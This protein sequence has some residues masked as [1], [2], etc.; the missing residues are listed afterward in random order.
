MDAFL[1][2]LDPSVETLFF[3]SMENW[4]CTVDSL[5]IVPVCINT[6]ILLAFGWKL[7]AAGCVDVQFHSRVEIYIMVMVLAQ[8]AVLW[9]ANYNRRAYYRRRASIVSALRMSRYVLSIAL[10]VAGSRFVNDECIVGF[11]LDNSSSSFWA[12]VRLMLHRCHIF[13]A[14]FY[15][16]FFPLSFPLHSACHTFGFLPLLLHAASCM[17]RHM[18]SQPALRPP[19]C[20]IAS[21]LTFGAHDNDCHPRAEQFVAY[22]VGPIN[23][24]LPSACRVAQF[25]NKHLDVSFEVASLALPM[26]IFCIVIKTIH[27]KQ[28]YILTS[29]TAASSAA[30]RLALC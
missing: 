4:L 21:A 5:T 25:Q 14:H 22:S 1:R 6:C 16:Y 8:F 17:S 2:F 12:V 19:V 15:T 27:N 3:N 20:A 11:F 24:S 10:S 9:L 13:W 7:L 26:P 23:L 18:L 29:T 30:S 28:R